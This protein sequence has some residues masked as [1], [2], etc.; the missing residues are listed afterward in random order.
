MGCGYT[1][2]S[3]SLPVYLAVL[4][5][6]YGYLR[7]AEPGPVVGED[8]LV[9]RSGPPK[10]LDRV[11]TAIRTRHLSGRTEEAYAFWIRRYILFHGKRPATLGADDVTRFLSHLPRRVV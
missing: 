1:I 2:D 3:G 9:Y 4:V 7:A 8:A 10:L 11:R 6:A 5:G